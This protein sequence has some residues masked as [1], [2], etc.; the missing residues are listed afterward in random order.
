MIQF[1][2]HIWEEKGR[3]TRIKRSQGAHTENPSHF[4]GYERTTAHKKM[5]TQIGKF[6]KEGYTINYIEDKP[7]PLTTATAEIFLDK[8]RA[9]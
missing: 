5:L 7:F 8:H 6:I 1:R 4:R 3:G 9:A 2:V